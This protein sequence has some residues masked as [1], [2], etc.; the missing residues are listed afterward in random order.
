MS[1]LCL[2]L[3][4]L[5]GPLL[6]LL[7]RARLAPRALRFK[8]SWTCGLRGAI[9]I[10][11][12]VGMLVG[13]ALRTALG[14]LALPGGMLVG[15]FC[16]SLLLSLDGEHG[17][18]LVQR[19]RWLYREFG[20]LDLGDAQLASG[21]NG[22]LT[23][24]SGGVSLWA[25]CEGFDTTDIVPVLQ[26]THARFEEV[27]GLRVGRLRPVRVL[28]FSEDRAYLD[29]AGGALA[30]AYRG[31][32]GFYCGR[33]VG[34]IAIN[35]RHT[36]LGGDLADIVAHEYTH[37][38]A[39]TTLGRSAKPWLN[40]GL[41]VSIATDVAPRPFAPGTALRYLRAADQR[42]ELLLEAKFFAYA[43]SWLI[44]QGQDRCDVSRCAFVRTFYLQ[45][46][47]II[48]FLRARNPDGLRELLAGY[49]R[50]RDRTALFTAALGLA[51]ATALAE[52][53]AWVMS[54]PL[55]PFETPSAPMQSY[56]RAEMIE[57][58]QDPSADRE[59]KLDA[60]RALRGHV[61][62]LEPVVR[63]LASDDAVL[64]DEAQRALEAVAGGAVA[65]TPSGWTEWLDGLDPAFTGRSGTAAAPTSRE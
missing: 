41:A 63:A 45:S 16:G 30:H 22:V 33:L 11:I 19:V 59:R 62:G 38:L 9:V 29:Y 51:P 65:R 24:A 28:V 46:G 40:E 26:R 53:R 39:A 14:D 25:D 52:F 10:S 47:S 6:G 13:L 18:P 15:T 31:T 8:F 64:R 23:R 5:I 44:K 34:R 1:F 7:V 42:G 54:Q 2:V 50:S 20:A 56:Y 3:A 61:W 60:L 35:A 48:R 58:L 55:P 57:P 12:T 4:V 49:R 43:Y 17:P 27:T 32:K 37:H 21:R 36:K